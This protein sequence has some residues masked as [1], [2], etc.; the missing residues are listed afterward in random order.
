MSAA[1]EHRLIQHLL[2]TGRRVVCPDCKRTVIGVPPHDW[3]SYA[4]HVE[5]DFV[6]SQRDVERLRRQFV[7]LGCGEGGA[8]A[9]W[10]RPGVGY[11]NAHYDPAEM[12]P[13]PCG[14]L[15]ALGY[16]DR[17]PARAGTGICALPEDH[18]GNHQFGV[19]PATLNFTNQELLAALI[20]ARPAVDELH[21]QGIGCPDCQRDNPDGS[22]VC[23]LVSDIEAAIT[24]AQRCAPSQPSSPPGDSK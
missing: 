1:C 22:P 14:P 24:R 23:F 13:T 10:C 8:E 2:P 6:E 5:R 11:D 15:V 19:P 16:D 3:K 17:C 4:E 7:C 20:K 21:A 18:L 12:N 9:T